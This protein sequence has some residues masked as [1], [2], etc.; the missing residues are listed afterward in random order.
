MKFAPFLIRQ[1][2]SPD[3][4]RRALEVL[5]KEHRRLDAA[6]IAL[7][8]RRT[9][10]QKWENVV[11]YA[12]V[13]TEQIEFRQFLVRPIDALETCERNALTIDIEKQI[14]L[15]LLERQKL[16]DRDGWA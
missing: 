15:W 2:D 14:A 9:V 16:L 8:D 12:G 1:A 11:T 7:E 6:W 13:V 5:L 10:L 4:C 3:E